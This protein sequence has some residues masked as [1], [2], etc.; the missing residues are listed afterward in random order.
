MQSNRAICLEYNQ[1]GRFKN[2]GELAPKAG[3]EVLYDPMIIYSLIHGIL[4]VIKEQISSFDKTKKRWA[5]DLRQQES[6]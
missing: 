2:I 4:K 3:G 1:L 5:P 6:I